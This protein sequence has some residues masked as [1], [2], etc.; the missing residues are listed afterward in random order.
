[1]QNLDHL[2]LD[3]VVAPLL[4]VQSILG[5]LQLLDAFHVTYFPMIHRATLTKTFSL[6]FSLTP[7]LLLLSVITLAYLLARKRHKE[8]LISASASIALYL[9]LGVKASSAILSLML[10]GVVLL[11]SRRFQDYFTWLLAL[12]TGFEGM[13]LIHWILLP[14]G[15]ASPLTW[16]ADLELSLFYIAAYLAPLLVLPLMFMWIL[17]PLLRWGWGENV[18]VGGIELRVRE[19]LS[20]RSVL[21]LALS[22]S[23]GVVSALY[24]YAS[25]VNP[26]GLSVGV[27][28]PHYVREAEVVEQDVS[29]VFSVWGRS[30]PLIHLVIYG[31]QRL[32]GLDVSTAVRFLPAILNPL[33]VLSVF[34]LALEV[35]GDGWAAGWAAFFTVC[36]FQVT[37]GMYSYFLT[38]MLG[39]SLV[40]FSLGFLFRS[41]RCGCR[42][43]LVLASLLGGLLVFTHPWTFDQYYAAAVLT[44]GVVWYDARVK[45]GD[46]ERVKLMFVY[47]VSLGLSELLKVLIF[48]GVGGVSASSTVVRRFSG[49]A[50]FWF[51]SIFSFRLLYGGTM[52]NLVLLGLTVVGVYLLGRR[53]VSE[54]F[55]TVFL[56]AT[57]LLFLV[58]DETIKSRLLYNVPIGLLAA[59]G[60]TEFLQK[61]WG[62][63]FKRAFILFVV[64]S[65][66]VYLFRS[67]ANLT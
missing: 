26:R 36:G 13:A 28:I 63:D 59:L 58:G 35:L 14:L 29:Q 16:F 34:F 7:V 19:G 27:D 11:Y 1:M 12:L 31:F 42:A 54:V 45:G 43:S 55:F 24:P 51:S 25:A 40:F 4:A 6:G 32:L 57:S 21:F 60:F 2:N 64:L 18:D 47:L 66:T 61:K 48:S 17:K 44:A 5:V 52:S 62:R 15:I 39:L 20:L 49:L 37:V 38:N 8:V 53:G 33:L 67:L 30:R 50:G 41:L 23:L 65:L 9:V 56:A 10:T 3:R 46:Y 22:V